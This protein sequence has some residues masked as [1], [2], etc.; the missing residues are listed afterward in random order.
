MKTQ[1]ILSRKRVEKKEK[2]NTYSIGTDL[3]VL[4]APIH[5]GVRLGAR[6][7][8]DPVNDG[9]RDVDALGP[10]LARQRLRQ[11]APPEHRRRERAEVG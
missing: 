5:I 4:H 10:E 7:V 11:P 8:D 2:K 9:M 6:D 1:R 3:A